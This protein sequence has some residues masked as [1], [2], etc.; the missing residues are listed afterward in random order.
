MSEFN[1]KFDV[2]L[3]FAGADRDAA[4][5]IA[6]ALRKHQL[7]VFYD[8][9][10]QSEIWGGNLIELLPEIYAAARVCI[11]LVSNS[12]MA[13]PYAKH[14][15]EAILE[16]KL[17]GAK[18]FLLPVRLDDT[19]VPGLSAAIA[20]IEYA[21]EGA[22]KIAS[23]AAKRLAKTPSSHLSAY[24]ASQ[25]HVSESPILEGYVRSAPEECY[26]LDEPAIVS[27][28][29]DPELYSTAASRA[30]LAHEMLIFLN[31]RHRAG[32]GTAYGAW[33]KDDTVYLSTLPDLYAPQK[34]LEFDFQESSNSLRLTGVWTTKDKRYASIHY[35]MWQPAVKGLTADRAD[36]DI[37]R[38]VVL[39]ILEDREA[40]FGFPITPVGSAEKLCGWLQQEPPSDYMRWCL[41]PRLVPGQL[42]IWQAAYHRPSGVGILQFSLQGRWSPASFRVLTETLM[43]V[44]PTR[45]ST[46]TVSHG[47]LRVTVFLCAIPHFGRENFPEE[48]HLL[49]PAVHRVNA[50][51][52]RMVA[53][54]RRLPLPPLRDE[55]ALLP[56]SKQQQSLFR[57][58]VEEQGEDEYT[59]LVDG[60]D[61]DFHQAK[62]VKLRQ[63]D[64][65]I[66]EPR[67]F[68]FSSLVT[69]SEVLRYVEECE[70]S[71]CSD[72]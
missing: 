8:E 53:A 5:A 58:A 68:Q 20:Y 25:S 49:T 35:S 1:W 31:W 33:R 71:I 72:K 27:A 4:R 15:L 19:K 23:M 32:L 34:T 42:G 61:I 17:L 56:L 30:V 36:L 69:P 46:F 29:R 18:D 3:S 2:A 63:V 57:W 41:D 65:G 67:S 24:Q 37:N 66:N 26:K 70:R 47:H 9:W 13:R 52:A 10:Y 43:I 51:I 28:F 44:L 50:M 64:Y 12:Y 45:H 39:K 16:R 40:E 59:E 55:S 38:E 62:W 6:E 22:E 21:R 54:K 60:A 11:I 14:E 7:N 48:R